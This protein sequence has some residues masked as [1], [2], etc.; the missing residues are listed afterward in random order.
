MKKEALKKEIVRQR[1]E[2][3]GVIPVVRAGSAEEAKAAVEAIQRGGVPIVEITMTVPGAIEIIR[4][5]TRSC[6]GNLLV[7][8]GTVLD[9]EVARL[10]I[11]AGA[12]FIVAPGLDLETVREVAKCGTLMMAAGLTPTEIVAAWKAG[13]DFVKVF[14]C[15]NVGGASYIKALRSPLPQI[16]L[17]PTGGVSL[18][19]AADLI[20]AGAVALGVGGELVKADALQKGN[21]DIISETARKFLDIVR[22]ARAERDSS[23]H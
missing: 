2:Q 12:Q 20:R 5:V 18:K 22:K 6:D 11:D 14:P 21:L 23:A 17:V 16:P 15:G 7:G 9:A 8:A 10:C 19:N 1:I 3:I 13:A 4:E